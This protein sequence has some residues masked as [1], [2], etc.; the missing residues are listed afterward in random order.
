M[1]LEANKETLILAGG[2]VVVVVALAWYLKNKIGDVA[3]AVNPLNNDN[4]FAS[5]TDSITANLTDGRHKTFGGWLFCKFNPDTT[6][7]KMREGRQ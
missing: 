6:L 7:C 4:I 5:A 2:A 1:S 3:E